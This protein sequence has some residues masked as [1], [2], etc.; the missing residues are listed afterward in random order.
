MKFLMGFFF[1]LFFLGIAW[2]ANVET[3]V[4]GGQGVTVTQSSDGRTYTVSPVAL[5]SQSGATYTLASTDCGS[6]IRFT[7]ASAVTVTI[8][9]TLPLNCAVAIEQQN[10]GQ[11]SVNGSAVTAATLHSA[12]SYVKTFGQWAIIDIV[13]ESNAGGSAAIAILTGDGA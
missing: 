5:T 10:T 13:I 4:V 2:G 3:S 7:S 9:A 12:H 11:V 8:P 6:L 1:G